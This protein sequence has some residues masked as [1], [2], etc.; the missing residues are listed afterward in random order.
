[1]AT[2]NLSDWRTEVAKYVK[3][4]STY[5]STVDSEVKETIRDFCRDTGV[6]KV[7]LTRIDTVVDTSTYTLTVPETNGKAEICF[8]DHVKYKEDGADD[9]QFRSLIPFTREEADLWVNGSWSFHD[10]PNPYKFYSNASKQLILYP[11]PTVESIAGVLVRVVVRPKDD[12]TKVIDHIYVDYKKAIAVGTA[13][14]LMN[15]PNKPWSNAEMGQ[16]YQEQYLARR[17]EAYQ[18]VKSG[19][20]RSKQQVVIPW[21]GGSRSERRRIF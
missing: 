15:M 12:A 1:M 14:G 6:W 11:I 4:Q 3:F 7:T 13:A 10:A 20:T 17:D 9:D 8:I 16:F 5:D 19:N 21:C 18:M 2:K